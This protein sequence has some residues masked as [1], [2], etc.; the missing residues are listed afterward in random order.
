[1]ALLSSTDAGIAKPADR[2]STLVQAAHYVSSKRGCRLDLPEEAVLHDI[3]DLDLDA[4]WASDLAL[5]RSIGD[6]WLQ[7]GSS[8]GL[9]VPS[10]V[11]PLE[12]KLLINPLHDQ[13]ARIT[14][15]IERNP[16]EFDPRMF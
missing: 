16:V 15:K 8:L 9:W 12:R 14:L 6:A 1:L 13:Y 5:T 11:E 10:A 4:D 3:A 2:L 7:N